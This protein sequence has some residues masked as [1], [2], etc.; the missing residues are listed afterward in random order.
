MSA[1]A[2][3]TEHVPYARSKAPAVHEAPLCAAAAPDD[4][5]SGRTAS[6]SM[7]WRRVLPGSYAPEH[8]A[9]D[10]SGRVFVA[11]GSDQRAF[12]A[13]ISANGELDWISQLGLLGMDAVVALGTHEGQALAIVRRTAAAQDGGTDSDHVMIKFD[14]TGDTQW[15][16]RVGPHAS[17][18]ETFAFTTDAVGAIYVAGFDAAAAEGSTL[19]PEGVHSVVMK[20][21]AQGQELA[22]T[23]LVTDAEVSTGL[24]IGRDE[25]GNVYAL[26][27]SRQKG[28]DFDSAV[29]RMD[30]ELGG[31]ERVYQLSHAPM[32]IDDAGDVRAHERL[33]TALDADP[34]C[35]AVAGPEGLQLRG[36][37]AR[38]AGA[39][40][41]W[42]RP[43]GQSAGSSRIE[44]QDVL[45]EYGR[46]GQ[47]RRAF[48]F[49][50][51]GRVVLAV[52]QRSIYVALAEQENAVVRLDIADAVRTTP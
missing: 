16:T 43:G 52:T 9:P 7:Q 12:V 40:Y 5:A 14:P 23:A 10:A 1:C 31:L 38:G 51:S 22:R 17:A 15:S 32:P 39:V 18:D 50:V 19:E 41:L 37:A 48:G 4:D 20:Y 34:P 6:L 42:A 49:G 45:L 27:H 35:R 21:D 8:I 29:F 13:Q 44:A 28:G 33:Y 26:A 47:L 3:E 2:A 11:G 24:Q 25:S 46:E 30:A 36:V